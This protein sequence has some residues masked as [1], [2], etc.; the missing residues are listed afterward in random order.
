M[1]SRLFFTYQ[2]IISHLIASSLELLIYYFLNHYNPKLFKSTVISPTY[3]T[4]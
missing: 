4:F 1:D 2:S 3:W